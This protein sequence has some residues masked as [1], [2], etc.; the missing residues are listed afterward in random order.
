MVFN[1]H[2]AYSTIILYHIHFNQWI[3]K[4]LKDNKVYTQYS[5]NNKKYNVGIQ[6]TRYRYNI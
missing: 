4:F 2:C 6:N 5:K 1:G 3:V